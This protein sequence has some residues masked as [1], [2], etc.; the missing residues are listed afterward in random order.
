MVGMLNYWLQYEAPPNIELVVGYSY[1]PPDHVFG[2]IEKRYN[3]IPEVVHPKEYIDIIKEFAKVYKIGNDVVVKDW[4]SEAQKVL[5]Q[6]GFWHFKFQPSKR[7]VLSK[8]KNIPL[9]RGEPFYRNDIFCIPK[10]LCKRGKFLFQMSRLQHGVPI[11]ND[12]KRN[13]TKLLEKH[14]GKE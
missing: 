14:N 5:K 10:S 6:Q 13:I 9:V 2:Q 4:R 11:D 12:K 7:I 8:G 1:I 3:K